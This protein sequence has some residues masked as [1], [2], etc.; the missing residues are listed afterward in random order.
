MPEGNR[1]FGADPP[2]IILYVKTVQELEQL[3]KKIYSDWAIVA[4]PQE[5]TNA[6]ARY[7]YLAELRVRILYLRHILDEIPEVPLV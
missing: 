1:L 3:D 5:L 2:L 4:K 6:I 7:G